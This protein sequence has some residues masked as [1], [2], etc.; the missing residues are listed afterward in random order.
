MYRHHGS[1]DHKTTFQIYSRLVLHFVLF[2]L[3]QLHC[4]VLHDGKYKTLWRAK[5]TPGPKLWRHVHLQTFTME[6]THFYNCWHAD[7]CTVAV[8][9]T[10]N[11]LLCSLQIESSL[12]GTT[13]S[14]WV[15]WKPQK[16]LWRYKDLDVDLPLRLHLDTYCVVL[17]W[18]NGQDIS[19]KFIKKPFSSVYII[20]SGGSMSVNLL[21]GIILTENCM[22]IEKFDWGRST[23]PINTP[24]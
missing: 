24:L 19:S 17:R 21:F 11:I 16:C 10:E 14:A 2:T 12:L 15:I 20:I 7:S 9:C 6:I 23:C 13:R 1:H 5:G 3:R 18:N 8:P 22:K 4:N